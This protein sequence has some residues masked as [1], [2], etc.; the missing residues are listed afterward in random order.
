MRVN[1]LRQKR[2]K[3]PAEIVTSYHFGAV[4]TLFNLSSV[5]FVE[6][7]YLTPPPTLS[8]RREW[9]TPRSGAGRRVNPQTCICFIVPS[10]RRPGSC[11]HDGGHAKDS[12]SP[13]RVASAELSVFSRRGARGGRV[14]ASTGACANL[15]G[16]VGGVVAP[17]VAP[18]RRGVSLRTGARRTSSS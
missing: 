4:Q 12:M 1:G 13:P 5:F 16:V 7:L 18:R 14:R 6:S 11:R 15:R 3:P 17:W 10:A 9:A 8:F 2:R